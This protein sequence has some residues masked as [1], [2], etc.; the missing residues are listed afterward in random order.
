M[1]PSSTK[2]LV[3]RYLAAYT[4]FD[5][6]GM[7]SLLSPDVVFENYANDQLTATA[8]GID[9]F[10]KLA[11]SSRDLFSERSQSLVS[12][13]VEDDHAIAV[14]E[15]RGRLSRGIADG[16]GAGAEIAITGKSEFAF[17]DGRIIRIVDRS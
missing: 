8:Q 14:I 17:R 4:A 10:R 12:L 11:E 15:F 3:D 13:R 2:E 5:V 9:E 16:P 7:L 1:N 6:P